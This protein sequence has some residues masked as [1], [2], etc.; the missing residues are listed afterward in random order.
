MCTKTRTQVWLKTHFRQTQKTLKKSIDKEGKKWQNIEAV[1]KAAGN[2]AAR[3][4][5]GVQKQLEKNSRNFR[6]P[7]DKRKELWY[8]NRVAAKKATATKRA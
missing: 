7:I 4:S 6:K 8:N 1:A 5:R 2:T 3:V